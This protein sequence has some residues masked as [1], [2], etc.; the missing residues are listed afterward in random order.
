LVTAVTLYFAIRNTRDTFDERLV[1]LAGIMAAF[2]FA[3]QM[4]NFPVAGGTSGHLIGATLAAIVLGPWL[5]IL[6]MTAVIALQALLFQDGG[7]VVMGA[8]I[9]VMG[10]I[11][12][13][14]GYGLY[15]T[16]ANRSRGVQ[17]AVTAIAAW[18]SVM[19]AALIVALLLGFS[20]TS[21]FRIAVPAMLGI[22][23]LIGIGEALITTAALSFVFNARPHLLRESAQ[24]GGRGW[25]VGGAIVTLLV[26]LIS[27]FASGFPDGLEW[28]AEEKGFLDTA[29]ASA[30]F[31][32]LPDYTI[33]FL[34]ETGLSTIV[35]GL[36]G[37][38]IVA[39]IAIGLTRLLRPARLE[40]GD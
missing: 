8:N 4:I 39:L 26:V 1:P 23:A 12:A 36:V 25:I 33:P 28:V 18:L 21:S 34:G 32:L 5:G 29:V 19:A 37:V 3:G 7:L 15:R 14:I 17:L 20:G 40:T 9:L 10:I 38:L 2:I 13:L 24:A 6:V 11:P 31:E 16:V 30:P 22:H 27:P 35:A